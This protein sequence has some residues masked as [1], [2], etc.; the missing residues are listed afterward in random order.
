MKLYKRLSPPKKILLILFFLCTVGFC[1]HLLKNNPENILFQI[2]SFICLFLSLYT[3]FNS[4]EIKI[5]NKIFMGLGL[6]VLAGLLLGDIIEVFQ[7]VGK[8][9]IQMIKMIVVP[10]VFAS[11]LVG[12]AS[13]ND[14][15]K[16][17]RI[18]ARTLVFYLFSTALAIIIGLFIANI[19]SPG[20]SIPSEIQIELKQD[21]Q[22][23]ADIKIS[24]AVKRPST[25]DLLLN[26]IPTNPAQAMADGEMLQIIFF[27]IV[28]GIALT[29][30]NQDRRD[31]VL[32]FFNGI[33]DIT[34]NLVHII[35][36]LAPYGVFS[37]MA[38]V[39][40]KYG[41]DIIITLFSYFLTTILALLIHVIIFNSAVIKLFTNVNILTFWRGIYPA[42]LVAFSTSSS[43]ATLP[44][45]IECAEKNLKVKPEVASFV[46]PL[47]STINMDGTAIFQGV[48][49]I[50]IATIYG[51][52]LTIGDQLTIIL[53]ATL[54]SIG[55]AG[56]PQVGIIM[57]TLV[58]QSIGIPLEG[59]AL[60]LG[61]ERF[62]DMARTTV[63]ITSDLSCSVFINQKE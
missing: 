34:I 45:T 51:M 7:P 46:L 3:I 44:V 12:T 22:Q 20:A 25:V 48:S 19:I 35:M 33:T 40:G 27:A 60:I 54:A 28:C 13:M 38:F 37:L 63:N 52:D 53:T 62:L 5:Y 11:L 30:V 8:A 2:L 4:T 23:E 57:L 43:S 17:G 42:L 47:G 29:Y 61:V 14:I 6:G 55:A 32:K 24:N 39:I 50:F 56:A 18:G 16:L 15:K 9:F 49:A 59:I 10:L 41:S 26:I 1:L 58:L 36:K 31:V 21:Y